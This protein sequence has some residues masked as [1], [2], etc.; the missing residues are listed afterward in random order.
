[1]GV[2]ALD[3]GCGHPMGGRADADARGIR[4]RS[5]QRAGRAMPSSRAGANISRRRKRNQQARH[6]RRFCA[7]PAS[8]TRHRSSHP[9]PRASICFRY[10]GSRTMD[11]VQTDVRYRLF[12]RFEAG[13][14]YVYSRNGEQESLRAADPGTSRQRARGRATPVC[15]PRVFGDGSR[16]LRRDDWVTDLGIRYEI[17]SA[18]S[19]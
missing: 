13:G 17:P 8:D 3:R 11:Q 12:D 9:E 14:S 5:A 6:D 15:G 4:I 10:E 18:G 2:R 16:A 7:W 19:A 1:M